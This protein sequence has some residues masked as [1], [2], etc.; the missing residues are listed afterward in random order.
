MDVALF[1]LLETI[2]RE[3]PLAIPEFPLLRF[4]H[5]NVKNFPKI[6]EFYDSP[7]RF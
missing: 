2:D 6:K 4:F 3:L 1:A 5:E 7:R